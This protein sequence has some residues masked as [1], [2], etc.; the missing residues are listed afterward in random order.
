MFPVWP[1]R[2]SGRACGE[3]SKSAAPLGWSPAT[4]TRPV[5]RHLAGQRRRAGARGR[6]WTPR[7]G[8]WPRSGRSRRS[9]PGVPA[10]AEQRPVPISSG[11]ALGVEPV[12]SG[13]SGAAPSRPGDLRQAVPAVTASSS[14]GA[15]ARSQASSRSA[16]SLP[17]PRQA[18]KQHRSSAAACGRTAGSQAPAGPAAPGLQHAG[19]VGGHHTARVLEVA[20]HQRPQ[21]S[22]APRTR[23]RGSRSR[24]WT[25]SRT[26]EH[27]VTGDSPARSRPGSAGIHRGRARRMAPSAR[28]S[29]GSSLASRHRWGSRRSVPPSPRRS[30][31]AGAAP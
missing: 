7:S 1:A 5:V 20:Q 28:S 15:A 22:R 2:S 18:G 31:D 29:R 12:T 26:G 21:P 24:P 17:Q 25:C 6:G 3:R 10:L 9:R 8:W 11:A 23:R 27:P 19:Q 4:Q 14:P 30:A 16:V 13:R